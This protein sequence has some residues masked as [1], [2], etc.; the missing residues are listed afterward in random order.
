MSTAVSEGIVCLENWYVSFFFTEL[1][2]L[3][4]KK[5]RQTLTDSWKNVYRTQLSE[6]NSQ[7]LAELSKT[8]NRYIVLLKAVWIYSWISER[9][10]NLKHFLLIF[11]PVIVLK[12]GT[13]KS[14]LKPFD[15]DV[16]LLGS[17]I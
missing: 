3:L 13:S 1:Q 2:Q 7:S 4:K 11:W 5:R 6:I 10:L 16:L 14:V 15:S 8:G 17:C 9:I 12:T